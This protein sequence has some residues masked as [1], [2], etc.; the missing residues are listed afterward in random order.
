[1]YTLTC[2]HVQY[3]HK[4][5]VAVVGTVGYLPRIYYILLLFWEYGNDLWHILALYQREVSEKRVLV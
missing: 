3:I 5:R 2:Y 4:P 1:M